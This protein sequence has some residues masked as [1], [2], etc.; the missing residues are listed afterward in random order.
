M[1]EFLH[2]V[3]Y[4]PNARIMTVKAIKGI[5]M[6][7]FVLRPIKKIKGMTIKLSQF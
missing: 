5:K 3:L 1:L 7:T 4:I 2:S 6:K